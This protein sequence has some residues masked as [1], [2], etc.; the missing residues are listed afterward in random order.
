MMKKLSVEEKNRYKRQIILTEVGEEGQIHLAEAKVLIIG[1]G[2]L[3]S[4]VAFYLGAAGVGKIGLV[5]HD[6]VDLSNLQRQ[7]LHNTERIGVKKVDSGKE[8]LL[9]LNPFI[10]IET[11]SCLLDKHIIREIIPQY[12]IVVN[13]VDNIETRYVLNEACFAFKKPL[14]EG[15]I[16]N[17]K[18]HVFTII[19]GETACYECVFPDEE[20][21][22]K[23]YKEIGIIGALP[24]VIGSLQAME[25]LK[26]ILNTGTLIT[27][28]ILY[29]NA[30]NASFKEFEMERDKDCKICGTLF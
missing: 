2:G 20:R 17:F 30:L 23:I 6:C 18:G 22:D 19:P 10:S 12:D 7:I 3:G 28:R 21:E 13:A 5:D 8:T 9:K 27:D 4:P 11:Y 25:V 16:H 24:G 15:A 29:Y 26:F 1:A 14:I